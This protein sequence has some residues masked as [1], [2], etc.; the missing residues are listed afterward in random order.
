MV[1]YL[2]MKKVKIFFFI[3]MLLLTT[4][5]LLAGKAKFTTGTIYGFNG[6][7]Y[8]VLATGATMG[9]LN[10]TPCANQATISDC[11]GNIWVLYLYSGGIYTPLYFHEC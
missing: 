8:C 11:D 5:G 9:S 4:A 10:T 6:V 2:F 1:K 7:K 3:T